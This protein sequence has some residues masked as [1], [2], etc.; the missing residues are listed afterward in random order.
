MSRELN[1]SVELFGKA[2]S[3]IPGGVNSPVRA[4]QQVGGKPVFVKQAAGSQLEDVDG[5]SY[6]DFCQSWGPLILGHAR[7]E[8]VEAVRDAAG[9]GLSY[10]ACHEGEVQNCPTGAQCVSVIRPCPFRQFRD[11]GGHD[12]IT[13][14]ARLYRT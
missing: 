7:P 14:C 2:A 12:C 3:L 1:G 4:F 9:M 6:T 8:V 11:R 10:G 5:N 13:C